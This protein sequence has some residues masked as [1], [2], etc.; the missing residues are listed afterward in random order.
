MVGV[1]NTP[2]CR[3]QWWKQAL[4]GSGH[5][6]LGGRIRSRSILAVVVIG[7]FIFL[8]GGLEEGSSRIGQRGGDKRGGGNAPGNDDGKGMRAGLQS[9]NLAYYRDR[10]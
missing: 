6:S 9:R 3:R 4:R 7:R 1:G 8:G 10:V 2:H 5:T